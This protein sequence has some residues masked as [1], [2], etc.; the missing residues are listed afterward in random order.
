M[1]G[2]HFE[3][4]NHCPFLMT[5]SL[6]ELQKDIYYSDKVFDDDYEYRQVHLPKQMLN[7]LP[8]EFLGILKL[9]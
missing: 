6:Q 1:H 8:H 5:N 3:T 7:L 2:S 4:T 9:M